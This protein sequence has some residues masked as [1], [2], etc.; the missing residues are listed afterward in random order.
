MTDEVEIYEENENGELAKP[1][2]KK[3]FLKWVLKHKQLST[4]LFLLLVI[5]L[6]YGWGKLRINKMQKDFETEKKALDAKYELHEKNSLEKQLK[7]IALPFSWAVRSELLSQNSKQIEHYAKIMIKQPGFKDILV[8]SSDDKILV[9]T[10]LNYKDKSID[11][12]F[13]FEFTEPK[14][15]RLYPNPKKDE[16]IV[17][18]PITASKAKLGMLIFS[19]E[20]N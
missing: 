5:L 16:I 9:T 1:N 8:A 10:D 11:V 20:S 13:P 19:F 7:L 18:A 6:Q 14:E 15:I 3:K 2:K 4:I 12:F 17:V